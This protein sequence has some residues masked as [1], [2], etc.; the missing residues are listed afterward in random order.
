MESKL[1]LTEQ[2][3]TGLSILDL[4]LDNEKLEQLVQYLQLLDKWNKAY[5]LSG[6]KE[7]Q[8]M[9]AYHLLDSLAIVPHIDGNIILDVGTG[10]G[11][12]GIPLAI[13]FPEKKF[14]L[15]DSN[16]KKTRFLFQVRMELGL[17]NV[18]VFHNRLET[19]QSREQIDIVLCRAYA[20]LSRVV[21]QCSHL[22]KADCRLLAMKGQYPEEEIL[23]LPASFRF[24]KTSE[25]NVPGVDGNRHLIEIVP[26][27]GQ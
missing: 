18:E 9:V 13:C 19:F 21:S 27:S 6:I 25:L 1:S 5:N 12:P 15:L 23:E 7:V 20:T 2:L 8:R 24:V 14:L 22:M 26:T 17:E 11:L 16:G 3:K 10:A 4:D